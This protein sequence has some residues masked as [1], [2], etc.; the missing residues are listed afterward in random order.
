MALG[1]FGMALG[2][3]SGQSGLGSRPVGARP[4][5]R[6]SPVLAAGGRC[7]RVIRAERCRSISIEYGVIVRLVNSRVEVRRDV[8]N[9]FTQRRLRGWP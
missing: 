8:L 9:S 1:I 6:P 3:W 7:I 2:M 4:R 5:S